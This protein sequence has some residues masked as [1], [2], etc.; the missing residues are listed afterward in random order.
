VDILPDRVD[1]GGVS[2]PKV[3]IGAGA[4]V[5]VI[6]FQ[7]TGPPTIASSCE[8]WTSEAKDVTITGDDVYIGWQLY[9]SMPAGVGEPWGLYVSDAFSS[10]TGSYS[11]IDG[12]VNSTELASFYKGVLYNIKSSTI[13]DVRTIKSV[14]P[15]Q[16]GIV[17][18][19][20]K[21]LPVGANEGD[22]VRYSN[23][24]ARW[25]SQAE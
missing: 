4:A 15:W 21:I 23:S 20:G 19:Q 7:Q 6:S 17:K 14:I 5:V 13:D 1:D 12:D 11:Y 10:L 16:T 24:Y 2:C 8:P 9:F 22:V 3:R 25:I 18:I